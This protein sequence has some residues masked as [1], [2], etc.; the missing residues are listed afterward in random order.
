MKV[1]LICSESSKSELIEL[2]SYKNVDISEDADIA[3]VESGFSVPDSILV[4][5]F[6]KENIL[7][8]FELLD[9]ISK[10]NEESNTIIGQKDNHNL[11]IIPFKKVLYFEGKGNYVYCKTVSGK[12]R[13]K[14]KLYELEKKLMASEFVRVGKSFIVNISNI[15]E[16]IPWFGRR[17]VLRFIDN[18]SEIEVSKNYVKSFKS[19]LGI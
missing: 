16:I 15:K 7:K 4:I 17:L 10:R 11:E 9:S 2:L 18:K 14:E 8:M 6:K 12:Y 3:I 1:K 19:H 5:I 13:I